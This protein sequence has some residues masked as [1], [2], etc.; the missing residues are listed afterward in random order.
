MIRTLSVAATTRL[1]AYGLQLA[2]H[3]AKSLF[4]PCR[5]TT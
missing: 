1:L 5:K 2:N 4:S 3:L